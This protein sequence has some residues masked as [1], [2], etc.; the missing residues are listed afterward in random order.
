MKAQGKKYIYPEDSNNII[1]WRNKLG[2]STRELYDAILYTGS[3][4]VNDV[5]IYLK[6]ET[7]YYPGVFN[8][9][10]FIKAKMA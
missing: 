7:S 6:K 10:K 3:T 1:Y 8:F 5:K 4:S 9:W 2:V